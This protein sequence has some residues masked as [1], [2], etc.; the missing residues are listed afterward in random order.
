VTLREYL[1]EDRPALEE[2]HRRRALSCTFPET[3]S[4]LVL[5]R[6]VLADDS[7]RPIAAMFGRLTAEVDLIMDQAEGSAEDRW[8]WLKML[9]AAA[10]MRLWR[11]G[12]DSA[13]AFVAPEI[14]RAFG[15]RLIGLGFER[16]PNSTYRR[17]AGQP[18]EWLGAV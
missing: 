3:N 4:P 18:L 11:A 15:R 5:A 6:F 14:A 7:S 10:E 1:P 17:H 9:A 8:N 2:I 13:V 12:L 16:E